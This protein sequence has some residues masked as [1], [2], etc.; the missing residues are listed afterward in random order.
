MEQLQTQNF[1]Y[2]WEKSVF[3][4]R[5]FH[6]IGRIKR[7]N[8]PSCLGVH[9]QKNQNWKL[10]RMLFYGMLQYVSHD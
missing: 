8:T 10:E 1:I 3:Q 9:L 6:E 5:L 7:P 2:L 4:A